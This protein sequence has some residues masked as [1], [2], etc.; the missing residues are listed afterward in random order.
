MKRYRLYIL[1]LDG[2]L[3]RGSEPLPRAHE[4][5]QTLESSGAQIRYLTNNSGQT[6]HFYAEKL[7]RMGFDARPEW[8]YSSAIG[9]AKICNQEKL[10]P[11]FY[12][13]D[14]GLRQTLEE[15]NVPVINA[16][17]ESAQPAKAVVAGICR[18]FTYGW[19]NAALQQI[20]CGAKFIATN[21]DVTYPI[22]GGRVEPGAGAIVSAIQTASGVAPRV[23]GKPE[24]LLIRMIMRDAG[25]SPAEVLV[26][27]DRYETDILAGINAGVDTHLVLTGV[28]QRAPEGVSWS[29]DLAGL[30]C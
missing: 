18:T 2:T 13:G 12:V 6:R 1:D 5:V 15:Y 25:I 27:G 4:T 3:Y 21:T 23:I 20:L 8:I 19:L 9:A 28:T 24:P 10:S 29:S 30:V 22:E 26:V 11:A 14:P 16:E 17:H 7:Q